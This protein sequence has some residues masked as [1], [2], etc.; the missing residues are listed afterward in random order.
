MSEWVVPVSAWIGVLALTASCS[1]TTPSAPGLITPP[2][3]TSG[4]QTS[5]P[6]AVASL[7]IEPAFVIVHPPQE[8][9]RQFGYEVRFQLMETSGLSGATIQNVFVGYADGGGDNTGPGC[10]LDPLRVPPGA[11]AAPDCEL[12]R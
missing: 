12:H 4:P 6:A 7:I 2:V 1:G 10:W 8:L 11:G 9:E 3:S 5:P